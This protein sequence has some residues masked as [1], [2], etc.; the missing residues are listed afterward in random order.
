M[1]GFIDQLRVS[2]EERQKLKALGVDSPIGILA[3]RKASKLSFDALIG[4]PGRA[5]AIAEQLKALLGPDE[6]ARLEAPPHQSGALGARLTPPP[7]AE[8]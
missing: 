2:E 4:S 1:S 8:E 6:I 3:M 5:D 7:N